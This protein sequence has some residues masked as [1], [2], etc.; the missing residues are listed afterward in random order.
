MEY[1]SELLLSVPF[2]NPPTNFERKIL[3]ELA[4]TLRKPKNEEELKKA[5]YKTIF[6][7]DT[8]EISYPLTDF[9]QCAEELR[10]LIMAVLN[11]KK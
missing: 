9:T 4:E 7:V 3:I 10:P 8:S 2:S 6:V 11:S 1:S 5:V